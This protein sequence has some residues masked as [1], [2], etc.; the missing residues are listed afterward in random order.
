MPNRDSN[1]FF[2]NPAAPLAQLAK[3]GRSAVAGYAG[4]SCAF[5]LPM[6]M[7]MSNN[8]GYAFSPPPC[9]AI[10]RVH[11]DHQVPPHNLAQSRSINAQ[12]VLQTVDQRDW[13]SLAYRSRRRLAARRKWPGGA[14]QLQLSVD[15]NSP[16]GDRE[17]EAPPQQVQERV[18]LSPP[19]TAASSAIAG[20]DKGLAILDD[21]F[22][23]LEGDRQRHPC[24]VHNALA[25]GP[26][27]YNDGWEWQKQ[28]RGSQ[29][30]H[31]HMTSFPQCSP[32]GRS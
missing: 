21:P 29:S 24:V 8:A 30:N 10:G 22:E 25:V 7:A 32:L 6:A 4:W 14:Q 12:R 17:G 16:S 27:P 28:V 26:T 2:T 11:G 31:G 13:Q 23:E 3:V 19:A 5:S 15:S 1:H 20:E 9:N 18:L